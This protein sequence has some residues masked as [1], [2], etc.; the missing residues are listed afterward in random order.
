MNIIG[1]LLSYVGK[2]RVHDISLFLVINYYAFV[3]SL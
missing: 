3:R 2:E 1:Q